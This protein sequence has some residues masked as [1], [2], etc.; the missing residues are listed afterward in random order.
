MPLTK[1]SGELR[2]GGS[3]AEPCSPRD[4]ERGGGRN[5]QGEAAMLSRHQPHELVVHDADEGPGPASGS[6]APPA[7]ARAGRGPRSRNSRVTGSA[8]SASSRARRTSRKRVADVLLAQASAAAELSEGAGEPLADGF[9]HAMILTC[10]PPAREDDRPVPR[11]AHRG[12]AGPHRGVGLLLGLRDRAHGAQPLPAAP[13]RPRPSGGEARTPAARATR[14][15]SS[16]SSSSATTSSTSSRPR[17][18][19]GPLSSCS[20]RPGSPSRRSLS[21]VVIVIFAEVA[22]KTAAAVQPERFA[23]PAARV[24]APL[25]RP[26]LPPW[27]AP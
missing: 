1:P 15:G 16:G 12:P 24:L 17:S 4:E 10:Q 9:E 2:A 26:R 27:C 7:R 3:L 14:T 23:F 25:L 6:S 20:G 21:T 19:P 5:V 18:P 8:T 13:P 11:C 22:P